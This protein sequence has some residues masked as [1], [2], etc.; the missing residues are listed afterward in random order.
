MRFLAGGYGPDE[1]ISYD[2]NPYCGMG[3]V[4]L[5][6]SNFSHKPDKPTKFQM[7]DEFYNNALFGTGSGHTFEEY[8]AIIDDVPYNGIGANIA[9][10]TY[11]DIVS[12][13]KVWL[14][15]SGQIG[16]RLSILDPFATYCS[17]GSCHNTNPA[18]SYLYDYDSLLQFMNVNLSSH[19]NTYYTWPAAGYCP[20]E[21]V[22]AKDRLQPNDL[23]VYWSITFVNTNCIDDY[24]SL[25]I[26]V[27][28]EG[29][30]YDISN[31]N[32]VLDTTYNIQNTLYFEMD[33]TVLDSISTKVSVSGS[34]YKETKFIAGKSVTITVYDQEGNVVISY[35]VNFF[36]EKEVVVNSI[37]LD[38]E[39]ATLEVGNSIQLVAT[40]NPSN[41]TNKNVEWSSDDTEIAIV[42]S[43]GLVTA[44]K[45]GTTYINVKSSQNN[46]ISARCKITVNEKIV[47]VVVS[48]VLDKESMELTV[49]D[50]AKLN[51]TVNVIGNPTYTL[52][53]SSSNNNIASV[54]NSGNVTAVGK[55]TAVI[56][57]KAG[58]KSDSCIVIV[59]EK[60]ELI[61]ITLD[62]HTL[63]LNEGDRYTFTTNVEKTGDP[64]YTLEY[65]SSN[66]DV[67]SIDNN[68]IAIA[69]SN[70][71]ATVTVKA[72]DKTDTCI[73]T[74]KENVIS[75]VVSVVLD[76]DIL[77]LE[78]GETGSLNA[79]VNVTGNPEY[80]LEYIS[81]NENIV[82]VD[83]NGLVK[84]I[85]KGTATVTVKAS[86]K[87]DTCVVVVNEKII[88]EVVSVVLDKETLELNEGETSTLKAT[89]NVTGNPEYTLEYI[90]SDENVVT[91]NNNGL[92]TA[93]GEGTATI[94]AKASDKTDTCTVTVNKVNNPIE[95]NLN[96]TEKTIEVGKYFI[97]SP[98]NVTIDGVNYKVSYT[99]SDTSV[100]TC[101]G[102]IIRG[103]AQGIAI[104][105]ANVNGTVAATCVVTVTGGE[106]PSIT[107]IT[108]D[109]TNATMYINDTLKLNATV[110]KIGTIDTTV[111]WSSSDTDIVT[112]DASGLVTAVGKGTA[113]IIATAGNKTATC[114]IEVKEKP[115][116]TGI[117]LDKTDATLDIG[118]TLKL[119]ANVSTSGDIDYIVNWSSSNT[120]IATVD[121]NG[122]VTALASGTAI[123]TAT[124]DGFSDT[125][126]IV[127]NEENKIVSVTLNNSSI[128]LKVGKST[129][130]TATVNKIGNPSYTL[131]WESLDESIAYVDQ[132]GFVYA[133]AKGT[134]KVIVRAGDKS[135]ECIVTVTEDAQV[136]GI[137]LNTTSSNLNVGDTLKLKETVSTIGNPSYTVTWKSSNTNVATVDATGLVTAINEGT[138]T[139]TA[140][141]LGYSASCTI[142]VNKPVVPDY[143]NIQYRSY[144]EN[145]D[146]ENTWR[147]NGE[148][149]GTSGKSLKLEGLQVK[150]DTNIPGS[151]EY[152]SHVEIYGWENTWRSNGETSG[153]PWQHLRLEAIRIRLTGEIS[154]RYD[155]YYRLHVQNIGW[156][157][158][159]CNGKEAGSSGYGYRVEAIE[160]KL[161]E[162]GSPAPGY[163]L[164]SYRE[165]GKE[166]KVSYSTHV[167]NVGDQ[168]FVS[169]GATAGTSGQGLRLESIRIKLENIEGSIEYRT[170]IQNIGW[171]TNWKK[172]GERSGTSG[173]SLRLEAIQIR[174]TGKIAEEYD[175]YY[176]VHAQNIGWMSWAKNG[177]QSGTQNH[178]FRLE[179]I[180]VVLV[181]KGSNPP[182]YNPPA[183]STLSFYV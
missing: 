159:A 104:I 154:N 139:I 107:G 56:T 49:G 1:T 164:D 71:T 180:Q 82:T 167:Q 73:V 127:V 129:R 96:Y 21:S 119:N 11:C 177:E 6:Q 2:G 85:G 28:Y 68:G 140:S 144:V 25:S 79:T 26:K 44:R 66:N 38:K 88:S 173:K 7:K 134:T 126:T 10:G 162:K 102:N 93:I 64:E 53:Y 117:S 183:N 131:N 181:K 13:I 29:T 32:T 136:T 122:N 135:D 149:S 60:S 22:Y 148:S 101:T 150:L 182:A 179:A 98:T 178:S 168:A 35:P 145:N 121:N 34:N 97:I 84:A 138:A 142:K 5:S 108:L 18:T 176:R 3:A 8:A 94:T 125:C 63:E 155:I 153:R 86:N 30:D 141:V 172:D 137:K 9:A 123:I 105:S 90:S 109:K 95:I 113:K 157:D 74:V 99:S 161:V 48:V 69:K 163:V 59:N 4:L 151:V 133:R 19:T 12:S 80:T 175:V 14:D 146:W 16:H 46:N 39:E 24:S 169:N 20:I 118:N 111:T 81:S 165:K 67:L 160:I 143:A 65:T 128:N 91:I 77:E 147:T 45:A 156:L 43:N 116:V 170:H 31:I 110:T 52:T 106:T 158:W 62:K 57:A 27:N 76:K 51:A 89:V 174:L 120:N 36:S 61:S 103:K 58:I 114:T 37:S 54:D 23:P 42:S 47:P 152:S 50:K 41:A 112:V 72:L 87:T 100:A 166:I 15:D 171:E 40:V 92:V 17:I 55:G 83:N 78:E 33:P 124:V 130:L 70:G 115:K 132:D 75:E